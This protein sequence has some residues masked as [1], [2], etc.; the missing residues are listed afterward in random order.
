MLWLLEAM[1]YVLC[2]DNQIMC[3]CSCSAWRVLSHTVTGD[4][5]FAIMLADRWPLQDVAFGVRVGSGTVS[6]PLPLHAAAK[7]GQ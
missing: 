2:G 1:V 7:P 3:S 5:Q 4:R 6:T